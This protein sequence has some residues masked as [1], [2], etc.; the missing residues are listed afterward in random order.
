MAAA[1]SRPVLYDLLYP[2]S[3]PKSHSARNFE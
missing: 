2:A 3:S 1:V